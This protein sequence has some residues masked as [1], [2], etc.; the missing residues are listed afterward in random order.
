MSTRDSNNSEGILTSAVV[1]S[2]PGLG[3]EN[4]PD[5]ANCFAFSPTQ[6]N[7]LFNPKSVEGFCSLGGLYGMEYGLRTDLTAGLQSD[8]SLLSGCISLEDVKQVAL[9]KT[10]RSQRPLLSNQV[11]AARSKTDGLPFHDRVRVFGRNLLPATKRKGFGRLL[12]DAYNDRI[13]LLLTAAAVVS[14]SLGIYEAAS[15]QSQVDWIEGVAVCVAIFIVVSAT[16]VND[17][18]KE[19]QFVRLNKLV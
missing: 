10:T 13:I 12:W 5:G 4:G 3:A 17:W 18:Q 16:A 7:E 6:L 11:H 15:G 9:A 14:L 1:P 8:E 2:V 19:R